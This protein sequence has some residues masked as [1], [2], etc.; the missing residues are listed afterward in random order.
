MSGTAFSVFVVLFTLAPLLKF[1]AAVSAPTLTIL[2]VAAGVGAFFLGMLLT[3]LTVAIIVVRNWAA[4]L[5]MLAGM[6][7]LAGLAVPF[8][9]RAR[10]AW[11][12]EVL[13]AF[14]IRKEHKANW[15]KVL[16]SFVA[17]WPADLLDEWK[18]QLSRSPR[19]FDLAQA[20][21]SAESE[22][23]RGYWKRHRSEIL[24]GAV[25]AILAALGYEMLTEWI[26]HHGYRWLWE[27][28]H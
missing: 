27:L 23:P 17:T 12:Y 4:P 3:E 22:V 7:M 19:D 5:M 15:F 9:S 13:E 10:R 18:D 28:N 24:W 20:E 25:F 8:P 2:V 14:R 21:V 16:G 6:M 26:H 11:L 1:Q